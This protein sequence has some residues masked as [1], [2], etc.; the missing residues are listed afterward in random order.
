ML[1]ESQYYGAKE[2]SA[3]GRGGGEEG[4]WGGRVILEGSRRRPAEELALDQRPRY[5]GSPRTPGQTPE[6]EAGQQRG[7]CE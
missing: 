7:G 5:D 6:D 2:E 1:D 4:T 3:P